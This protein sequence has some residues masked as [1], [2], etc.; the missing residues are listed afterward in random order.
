M[1]NLQ[2]VIVRTASK[3][4]DEIITSR[5]IEYTDKESG[6]II[7]M[8]T[9]SFR[10]E[11]KRLTGLSTFGRM[12]VRSAYITLTQEAFDSIGE[13]LYD[14][15]DLSELGVQGKIVVEETLVP[16]KKKNGKTQDPK[17]NPSTGK[18]ILYKGKK[19]YRN[20]RFTED[21]SEQDILL[22]DN[23]KGG[24]PSGESDSQFEE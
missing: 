11:S 23:S 6:E 8:D 4:S 7:K 22:I 5:Q 16:Y 19:V 13:Q 12:Q 9:Y 1:Q 20:S 15:L 3:D 2:P 18:P 24:N 14:G 10:V 17:I 21:L